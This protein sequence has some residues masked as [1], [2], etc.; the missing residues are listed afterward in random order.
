MIPKKFRAW[1]KENKKM[2]L[3]TDIVFLDDGVLFGFK[4]HSGETRTLN[5][6]DLM[7]Y[8]G[9]KD[10]NGVEIYDSYIVKYSDESGTKQIGVVKDYGYKKY[11]EAIG[12]DDEGNQDL[13]L[14]PDEIFEIIGNIYENPELIK[15]NI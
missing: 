15:I 9:L 14:H 8:T 2:R 10:K 11:V 3:A 6:P 4:V 5:K 13:E 1:D 7:Q 12:G